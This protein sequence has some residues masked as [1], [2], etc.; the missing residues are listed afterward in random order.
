[1]GKFNRVSPGAKAGGGFEL[2]A[3]YHGYKAWSSRPIGEEI[4]VMMPSISLSRCRIKPN[5]VQDGQA[6][7]QTW[8]PVKTLNPGRRQIVFTGRICWK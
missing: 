1:M 2:W 7:V 5:M 8:R 3:S 6:G 4:C